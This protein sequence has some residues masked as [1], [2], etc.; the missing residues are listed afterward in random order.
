MKP[1]ATTSWRSFFPAAVNALSSAPRR[2]LL[3]LITLYQRTLSPVVP[4][5][6]GPACGC[7][8]HP[9]CSRYAAEAVQT[10]GAFRG[11]TL[12][13]LRLAKC[14][15]LHPGGVDPVPV[16]FARRPSCARVSL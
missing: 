4:A 1:S 8:F 16:C 12:A 15:P 11:A 5:L 9:S 2:V 7:R 10:H 3:G 6:F 13:L 14:T